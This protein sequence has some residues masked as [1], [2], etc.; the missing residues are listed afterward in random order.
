MVTINNLPFWNDIILTDSIFRRFGYFLT[1]LSI[2]GFFAV[3]C[4]TE[5]IRSEPQTA[6]DYYNRGVIYHN[7][8]EYDLALSDYNKA[9]EINPNLTEAYANRGGIFKEKGQCIKAISDYTTAT[10]KYNKE[11]PLYYHRAMCYYAEKNIKN[12]LDDIT[13]AKNLGYQ[14]NPKFLSAI[15]EPYEEKAWYEQ[16]MLPYSNLVPASGSKNKYVG[17]AE[18]P[19]HIFRG[20][21]NSD[22]YLVKLLPECV[23]K[24]GPEELS[25]T[26]VNLKKGRKYLLRGYLEQASEY[27]EG[28]LNAFAA[29]SGGGKIKYIYNVVYIEGLE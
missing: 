13:V 16:S 22:I 24:V 1:L 27:S 5:P 25:P 29:M 12:A 2:V 7:K 23:Y 18:K 20:G 14:I 6:V 15:Q 10:K 28:L 17:K 9:L 26:T 11:A 3:G 19:L 21:K 8:K 4:T